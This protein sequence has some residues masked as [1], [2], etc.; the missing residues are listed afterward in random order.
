MRASTG[1]PEII[2][3]SILYQVL[4]PYIRTQT[5]Y[6]KHASVTE[7][8]R[9]GS[10]L[11][12]AT[13]SYQIPYSC[14]ID[15]TGH[16]NAVEFIICYNQLAYLSFGHLISTGT[17]HDLPIKPLNDEVK[18]LLHNLTY[19]A[20][21]RQQLASM[22]IVKT[23]LTFKAPVSP[24]RF[25]GTLT[26]SRML[27]RRGTFFVKTHCAFAD[28]GPGQAHGDIMLAYPAMTA[29]ANK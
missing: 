1:Q 18:G 8:N 16:F 29:Q 20:F 22:F 24:E 26:I 5:D 15:S 14:Y 27:Y 13:G 6:L 10:E 23:D 9:K 12:S 3:S 17:L 21:L 28:D 25:Y 7:G 2:K 19:S 4:K 11:F